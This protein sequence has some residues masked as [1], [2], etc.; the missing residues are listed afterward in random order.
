[1]NISILT[2]DRK[3]FEGEIKSVKLPGTDGGFEILNRHAPL[4]SSLGA[5]EVRLTKADGSKQSFKIVSGF[6]EVLNNNISLLVQG[7]KE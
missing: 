5:G 2:P 4:V 3:V 6:V 7:V 1:M